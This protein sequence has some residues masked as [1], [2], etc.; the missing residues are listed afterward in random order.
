MADYEKM[1]YHLAGQV[2]KAIDLLTAAS[3]D[4]EEIYI[5]CDHESTFND[6]PKQAQETGDLL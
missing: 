4:T 5:N 6:H 2:A 3:R 1:Y